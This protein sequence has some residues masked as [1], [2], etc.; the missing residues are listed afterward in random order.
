MLLP[1]E[2]SAAVGVGIAAAEHRAKFLPAL[3]RLHSRIVKGHLRIAAFGP[4]G[5]GKTTLG[6]LFR[7][8]F[9]LPYEVKPY[10]R[11][12]GSETY[13]LPGDVFCT[14][15]VAPG[16]ERYSGMEWKPL[17]EQLARGKIIGIIN[18]VSWGY[19][20]LRQIGYQETKYYQAGMKKEEFLGNY[21]EAR[22][23][24]ELDIAR[25]L[26]QPLVLAPRKLWMMTLVTK[27]DLWWNER[28]QVQRHYMEGE[29]DTFIQDISRGRG[30]QNFRHDYVSASLVLDNFVD[31]NGELL[32]PTTAGYDQKTQLAYLDA[33]AKS[34]IALAKR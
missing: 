12:L 28:L 5:T 4:G 15:L 8:N 34:A 2:P 33:L 9:R 11:S 1:I 19:H 32:K 22:R 17:F 26:V 29:Y 30:E 24:V 14:L 13:D 10:Q 16:Q 23:Q 7:N 6:I 27:Q 21:L 20:S 3:R 31:V 25:Q 18:V